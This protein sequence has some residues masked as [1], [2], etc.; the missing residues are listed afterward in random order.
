[1][2]GTKIS[3]HISSELERNGNRSGNKKV[4]KARGGVLMRK[5]LY[6]SPGGIAKNFYTPL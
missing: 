3:D 5:P 1:M 6:K 4:R 2:G